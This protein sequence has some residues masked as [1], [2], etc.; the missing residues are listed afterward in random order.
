MT[1]TGGVGVV[2]GRH[3]SFLILD[4]CFASTMYFLWSR[5]QLTNSYLGLQL[6]H[7]VVRQ[8]AWT[9]TRQLCHLLRTMGDSLQQWRGAIGCFA[10]LTTR[11]RSVK[12]RK[13]MGPFQASEHLVLNWKSFLSI[14]F[15]TTTVNAKVGEGEKQ[16]L[17]MSVVTIESKMPV[18]LSLSPPTSS[19]LILLENID[20]LPSFAK[21][22]DEITMSFT[23]WEDSLKPPKPNIG[24]IHGDLLRSL[25]LQTI[26]QVRRLLRLSNDVETNP[27]PNPDLDCETKKIL[28]E[29]EE[30]PVGSWLPSTTVVQFE[31]LL[32]PVPCESFKAS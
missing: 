6:S 23:I 12:K 18:S 11:A 10:A 9:L 1:Y 8:L 17:Y 14:F 16:L 26:T 13:K 20:Q 15:L 2:A 7:E 19:K 24:K 30:I 22:H 31:L 3:F 25:D 21:S 29:T 4:N 27:G 32:K 5:R 28:E